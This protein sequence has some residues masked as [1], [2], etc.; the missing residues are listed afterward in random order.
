MKKFL[1][2]AV[3]LIA[4][5]VSAQNV[6]GPVL[7][8]QSRVSNQMAQND[9]LLGCKPFQVSL[10][11]VPVQVF[12]GAGFVERLCV[13]ANASGASGF[14]V[15]EDSNSTS[16]TA[17]DSSIPVD[18]VIAQPVEALNL[19]GTVVN[20][21]DAGCLDMANAPAQFANGLVVALSSNTIS[22]VGC[23]RTNVGSVP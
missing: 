22:A 11:T 1:A 9:S 5:N 15:V 17:V 16:G 8:G 4:A 7:A 23:F 14:G 3:L 19:T 13:F 20:S 21:K 10:T 12:T 2:L 6:V 18:L